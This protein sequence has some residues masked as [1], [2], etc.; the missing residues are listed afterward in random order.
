MR[1]AIVG[2][3]ICGFYLA[4]KLAEKKHKVFLFERKNKENFSNKACSTLLSER[5]FYF[6]PQCRNLVKNEIEGVLINFPKK[7]IEVKFKKKFFVFEREEILKLLFE[8]AQKEGVKIFFQKNI[9][10]LPKNFERIVGTDGALSLTRKNLNLRDPQ[11]FLG[12]QGFIKEKNFSKLTETFP[13]KEGFI[14]K[15]PRGDQTEWGIVERLKVARQIFDKFLKER[16]INLKNIKSAI[17][18]HGLIL[19]KNKNIT[20]L[21]DSQGLTKNWS[22]GGIIWSL[23]ASEI[24]LKN[25]PDFLKYEKELKKFFVPQIFLSKIIKKIVYFLGFNFP[26]FLPKKYQI[27][28]DFLIPWNFL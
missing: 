21:G 23:K 1:V 24:L 17:I 8:L 12:V 3:G 16:N 10:S 13:T 5:I 18:P 4:W 11:F 15:I 26:L 28:G 22:Y 9:T 27:D 25:F 7:T 2:G 19:T 20:L 6:I 14:W